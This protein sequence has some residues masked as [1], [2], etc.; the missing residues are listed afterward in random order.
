MIFDNLTVQERNSIKLKI[1]FINKTQY[2]VWYRVAG[3]NSVVIYAVLI[4][5]TLT[6]K[7]YKDID[8]ELQSKIYNKFYTKT[9]KLKAEYIKEP[10]LH[11][12]TQL[13]KERHKNV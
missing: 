5:H 3:K 8:K 12:K 7:E 13:A 6:R 2:K 11:E 9:H 4:T 1:M 10:T